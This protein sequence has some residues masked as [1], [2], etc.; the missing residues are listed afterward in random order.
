MECKKP[1]ACQAVVFAAWCCA[2]SSIARASPTSGNAPFIVDGNRTYAE[3]S[4]VRSDGS[5]RKTLAY[6]DMGSPKNAL[7]ASLLKRSFQH[8]TAFQAMSAR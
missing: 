4:F 8:F 2:A 1:R 5:L 7:S 6:I 3:V